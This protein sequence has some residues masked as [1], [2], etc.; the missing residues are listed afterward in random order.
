MKKSLLAILF[1]LA[2]QAHAQ[3]WSGEVAQ[4]FYNKCTA[5]H[6]PN[7]AAPMSLMTH[8]EVSPLAA[9][10]YQCV[11]TGEMPPW[12]PDNNYQQYQH[13]RALSATEK[14]TII[15]WLNNGAPE[16]D[17]SQTPPP[18]VYTSNT[19]LGNGDLQIQIP[20]Y[21]SKATSHDDYVCFR[22]PT[23]LT[24]NRIIKAV[25]VVPGNREIVHHCLIYIDPTSS[26]S[27]DTT[28]GNCAS[29]SSSNT[30]L[31]T[32]YTPGATP[33][34]LPSSD[35]LKLGFDIGQGSSIYFAMHYPIGSY[36]QY[37][38]TKVILH[39]YPVGTTNVRQINAGPLL[40]DQSFVLPANQ[41][42][43]LSAYFPS[44]TA[45]LPGN[46]SVLSVFPHMHLIGKSIKAYAY[47]AGQD[48]IHFASI[49]KWN[50]MWQDFYFFTHIQ[51]VPFGYHL[52]SEG[53][54]DNTANNP[55]NPNSPPINVFAGFNTTDEMF[56]TYFHY[57]PYQAGDETYDLEALSSAALQSYQLPDESGIVAY[58]NPFSSELIL[59][60][61]SVIKAKDQIY[62]YDATGQLRM[63][64][65]AEEWGTQIKLGQNPDWQSLPKGVY[66]ISARL[67]NHLL[68]KKLIKF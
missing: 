40:A 34:I 2:A 68:S 11:N 1:L 24:Q 33:M 39:F 4:L 3:T 31:V 47:K 27:T 16:G 36:G 30:K 52:K 61:P 19:F 41:V 49:P 62:L 6:H 38:S 12:P 67:D 43:S 55:N 57:L 53:I 44:Q 26:E 22:V 48:T 60:F 5:C 9:A 45:G 59:E 13:N 29:P 63:V 42:T 51:K 35:P 56:L 14:S 25:E 28:G 65:E 18:P 17:A 46:Y 58:P 8:A 50:F 64:L 66:F 7:G 23:N 21:M 37:D 15:N 54:Y 20:T 10:V 32:G